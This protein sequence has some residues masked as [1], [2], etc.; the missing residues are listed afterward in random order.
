MWGA[1]GVVLVCFALMWP[2]S[3]H[4]QQAD[5]GTW[6]ELG[7]ARIEPGSTVVT[8]DLAD[9]SRRTTTVR[10]VAGDLAWV[11]IVVTYA[12]GQVH[13]EERDLQTPNDVQL[14]KIDERVEGRIV[15]RIVITL[16]K[17]SSVGTNTITVSG[18]PAPRANRRGQAEGEP[19]GKPEDY[20]IAVPVYY[21][22]SRARE[23]DRKKGELSLAAY[24]ARTGDLTLGR[25]VVTVPIEREPGTIPRPGWIRLVFD[26]ED[27]A[28]DFTL[29][30]VEQLA[31]D[32]FSAELLRQSA[33]GQRFKGQAF[34]FVHGFNVSFDDGLFRTAQI[35]HD[36]G[37]DGAA[38][39]YSWP[40]RAN[41]LSYGYDLD[42]AKA[43]RDGL[44][45]LMELVAANPGIT[46]VNVIAHSLGNDPLIEVLSEHQQMRDASR[47]PN[48]KLNEVV[49]AAPDVSRTVF[50][51]M[52][53]RLFGVARGITLYASSNDRALSASHGVRGGHVRAGAVPSHGPV[54]VR[55]VETLDVSQADTG[56]FALNH[57]TFADRKHLIEDLRLLFANGIH[58]PDKRF[59][60]FKIKGS[61]ERRWWEYQRN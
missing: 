47:A 27:P 59:P 22:T 61:S 44:R 9:N 17:L 12:S 20:W 43:G 19:T 36:I 48:L 42:S 26:K 23:A 7:T 11:R 58:P 15:S 46:K 2:A 51:K 24:G 13:F 37:F 28:R 41:L 39:L 1:V 33:A 29:A 10:L 57:S 45:G 30:S 60:V 50:E 6:I 54:I 4:A 14:G 31:R 38:I 18:R 32:R 49:F 53:D 8:I 16:A 3:A 34:I 52:A 55:G 40:S 25:A 21:G 56:W 35:A 5:R